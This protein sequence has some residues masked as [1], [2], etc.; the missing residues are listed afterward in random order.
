MDDTQL[1]ARLRAGDEQAFAAI[2]QDWS[3]TMLH[4]AKG[5]VSTA[6]SAAE[7][8]Q[9]TWLAVLR[10]LDGF[11]ERSSLRTWV[12][13]ILVNT[14]KTRRAREARTLPWSSAFP[15]DAEGATVSAD[16]FRGP[17]DQWPGGWTPNGVPRPFEPSPESSLIAKEVGGLVA[18]A[19]EALPARQRTVVTLRDVDGLSSEEVC[20]LLDVSPENQRVL[21]H[22]GRAKVRAALEDYY[23][24]A[25]T[26]V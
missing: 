12:F 25:R 26:A 7:V 5:Y 2:V 17:D 4:V 1:V 19:L 15:D 18:A 10:G 24:G 22:R 14:A 13:R 20:D 6:E 23:T 3:P 16:R 9:D 8:V 21:L 11:E